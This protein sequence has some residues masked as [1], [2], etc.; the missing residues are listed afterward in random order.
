LNPPPLRP[1]NGP[2]PYIA[3]SGH[4]AA[5]PRRA[6]PAFA[7]VAAADLKR[8]HHPVARP[9]AGDAVSHRDDLRQPFMTDG[10]PAQRCVAMG[11]GDVEITARHR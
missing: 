2:R 1:A 5:G 3:I 6:A 4:R 9:N 7:A 10:V 11:D 8:H